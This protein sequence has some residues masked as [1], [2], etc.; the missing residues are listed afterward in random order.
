MGSVVRGQRLRPAWYL[1]APSRL[2]TE[3]EALRSLPFFTFA[4][5]YF[6]NQLWIVI[7]T[8]RF[9]W[10]RSRKE[11]NLQVRIEYPDRFPDELPAVFDDKCVFV[12]GVDDGHLF[13]NHALCLTCPARGEFSLGSDCLIEEVLG[14]S[15]VWLN[16]RLIFE[17][18]GRKDWPGP[19]EKHGVL[20][21][22]DLQIERAGLTANLRVV[23]WLNRLCD[24]ARTGKRILP[25][26]PYE[27][28]LCGSA[29]KLKFCHGEHLQPIVKLLAD[30]SLWPRFTLRDNNAL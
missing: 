16:K 13:W 28:C 11:E 4:H 8:L 24:D 12:T 23:N 7:G 2:E 14:A 21:N 1:L 17:R 9:T 19:A 26:D 6:R 25:L 22:I 18:N 20:A 27:P 29:K 15:L 10:E 30:K 3:R 5:E